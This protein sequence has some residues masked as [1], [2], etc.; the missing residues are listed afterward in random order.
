MLCTN[1]TIF[2][3]C[4]FCVSIAGCLGN[5]RHFVWQSSFYRQNSHVRDLVVA[6]KNGTYKPKKLEFNEEYVYRYES[7]LK[8][9]VSKVE[10]EP[11]I[12]QIKLDET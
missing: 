4:L 1:I 12:A 3:I 6:E 9:Q 10:D 8:R 7:P 11:N 5:S 2:T